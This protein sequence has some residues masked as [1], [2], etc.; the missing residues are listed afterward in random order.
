M[1][2][3]VDGSLPA[4]SDPRMQ[5]IRG[6]ACAALAWLPAP[7]PQAA[8]R[9]L[10][11]IAPPGWTVEWY[12][13]QWLGDAFDLPAEATHMLA[14]TNLYGLDYI[15]LQ[16]ALV[17]GEVEPAERG[18]KVCLAS[19]LY[20]LCIQHYVQWF[21]AASPFWQS[22][23]LFM[24]QW[25]QATL[26][27]VTQPQC[28]FFAFIERSYLA[29]AW[30]GAPLKICCVGAH[31]LARRRVAL[32]PLLAAI[33][34]HLT[35]VALLDHQRDWRADL[36]A[37]RYNAFVHFASPLPQIAQEQEANRSRVRA[38]ILQP[39]AIAPYFE[40]MQKHLNLALTYARESGCAGLADYLQQFAQE[41]SDHQQQ[42]VSE[43]GAFLQQSSR[44]LFGLGDCKGK[45]DE[46][47]ERR[48][49]GRGDAK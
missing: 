48:G 31:L 4:L 16:D 34:H 41:V 24:R 3:I 43:V 7:L 35:A 17:D 22:H 44:L 28:D 10:D 6:E 12:L 30:R 1:A 5:V 2:A 32:T 18:L 49:Q 13:A 15:C 25:W 45:E 14:L 23:S 46:K 27:S 9:L 36:T 47:G 39:H 26:E 38:L 40:Q 20:Q 19:A 21:P 42:T 37:G 29:L 8:I 11:S 33:D